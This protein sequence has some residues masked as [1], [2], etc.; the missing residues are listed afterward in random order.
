[1]PAAALNLK[2]N[3]QLHMFH[4]EL[5]QRAHE[6]GSTHGR[7]AAS[8][9][10]GA[11][12]LSIEPDL[13]LTGMV[14]PAAP[15]PLNVESAYAYRILNRGPYHATN[16]RFSVALPAGA[17][18]IAAS[19]G[20]ADCI[21]FSNSVA[22]TMPALRNGDSATFSLRFV[23]TQA[24]ATSMVASIHGAQ[25]DA[26]PAQSDT[27]KRDL[28]AWIVH[29]ECFGRELRDRRSGAGWWWR[30]RSCFA[31]RCSSSAG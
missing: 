8:D 31:V 12:Q 11:Q 2:T 20:S 21:V 6:S 9:R 16:I 30:R 5:R 15:L 28:H 13:E 24:Q 17:T 4:A 23:P 27:R 18:A 25:P 3:P 29:D 1:M 19:S 7:L 26:V 14:L 22:C 10:S